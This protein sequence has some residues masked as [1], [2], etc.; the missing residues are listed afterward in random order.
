M[1][2]AKHAKILPHQPPQNLH[3]SSL[4]ISSHHVPPPSTQFSHSCS[5]LSPFCPPPLKPVFFPS[6]SPSLPFKMCSGGKN[7]IVNMH[8]L[9]YCVCPSHLLDSHYNKNKNLCYR[10]GQAQ[11]ETHWG[12]GI[13]VEGRETQELIIIEHSPGTGALFTQW[14]KGHFVSRFVWGMKTTDAIFQL[15]CET[16]SSMEI[17]KDVRWL[18]YSKG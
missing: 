18:T 6:G 8:A 4:P 15:S 12:T 11:L 2:R 5:A 14:E 10:N 9:I 7:E 13:Q 3:G 17:W 1:H 16:D